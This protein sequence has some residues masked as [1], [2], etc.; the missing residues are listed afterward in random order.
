VEPCA[1][2]TTPCVRGQLQRRI[3]LLGGTLSQAA[4]AKLRSAAS[5]LKDGSGETGLD[6][7]LAEIELRVAVEI[8]KMTPRNIEKI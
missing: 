4:L 1:T 6:G 3:G 2:R 7:V 5:Y 8:A